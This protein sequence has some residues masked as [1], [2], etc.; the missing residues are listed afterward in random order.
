M[1]VDATLCYIVKNGKILLIY[2]K[3]GFGA[4]K[5]NGA[6]GKIENS[7]TE[8]Q[9]AIRET[10]EETGLRPVNAEKFGYLKF[11]FGQTGDPDMTVHVFKSEDFSGTLRETEEAKP[12]WFD[13]SEI[14]FK[15]MWPDDE[16]WFPLM[17]EDKKFSGD[18][19]FD[20]DG[21]KLINH[22]LEIE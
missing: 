18:F 4:G 8:K 22:N 21:K 15:E 1:T 19:Y 3:R 6:G 12:K 20:K 13:L 16:I 2:K 14:P 11:F 7:E 9:A 5:W 17:M 10:V